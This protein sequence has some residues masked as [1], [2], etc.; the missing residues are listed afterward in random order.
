VYTVLTQMQDTV[1]PLNSAFKYGRRFLK[2]K[3]Q[4]T[5]LDHAKQ[6]RILLSQTK[7]CITKFS[8]AVWPSV[9]EFVLKDRKGKIYRSIAG[10]E[11]KCGTSI[12]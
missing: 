6:K 8:I 11:A 1:L 7:V 2:L 3:Y 4:G 12:V 10:L 9:A 5:K